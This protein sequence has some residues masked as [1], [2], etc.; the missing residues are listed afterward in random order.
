MLPNCAICGRFVGWRKGHYTWVPYG[1][2]NDTEPP[3]DEY[4]H[5]SCWH[6]P[7]NAYLVNLIK[8]TSWCKPQRGH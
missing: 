4:A 1:S 2:T 6:N 5:A 7:K 8:K 3:D